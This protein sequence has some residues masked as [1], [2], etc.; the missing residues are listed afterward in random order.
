MIGIALCASFPGHHVTLTWLPVQR[1]QKANAYCLIYKALDF[2]PLC[3]TLAVNWHLASCLQVDVPRKVYSSKNSLGFPRGNTTHQLR[4][5]ITPLSLSQLF[6][7]PQ[8]L[9]NAKYGRPLSL[10]RKTQE[11]K[12]N[13]STLSVF[14]LCARLCAKHCTYILTS[15]QLT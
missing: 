2:K 9:E 4:G 1:G 14:F 15:C 7:H 11:S 8:R 10:V 6:P 12:I 3:G 13:E 5:P